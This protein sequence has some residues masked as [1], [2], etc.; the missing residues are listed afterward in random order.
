[1]EETPE[2]LKC[3]RPSSDVTVDE[4][5][6][7]LDLAPLMASRVPLEDLAWALWAR[8]CAAEPADWQ[9]IGRRLGVGT[10]NA[11]SCVESALYCL[12]Y[13]TIREAISENDYL[14]PGTRLWRAIFI[15]DPRVR[16]DYSPRQDGTFRPWA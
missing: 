9:K 12:R 10:T 6:K 2:Q 13:P 11:R 15:Q 5:R 8:Y 4:I 7:W 3:F 16:W 14:M 1:M